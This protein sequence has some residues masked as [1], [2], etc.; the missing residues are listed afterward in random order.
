MKRVL[1]SALLICSAVLSGFVGL[2]LRQSFSYEIFSSPYYKTLKKNLPAASA[3]IGYVAVTLDTRARQNPTFADAK[4]PQL[5]QAI[6]KFLGDSLQMAQI[7][8]P[9]HNE[10]YNEKYFPDLFLGSVLGPQKP[11]Y[12]LADC[13]QE[14][15]DPEYCVRLAGQLGSKAWMQQLKSLMVSQKLNYVIV[16]QLGEGYIYPNG[17]MKKVNA[18][19]ETRKAP[20]AGLDM[21]TGFWLPMSQKLVATNKPIDVLFL[22]GMLI[23]K[24]GKA[25]RYGAEGITAASKASF[26]E[27]TVNIAHE[28][29]EAE[30]N[31]IENDLRRTDLPDQPL[32]WQIAAKNLTRMLTQSNAGL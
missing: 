17:K 11:L 12:V 22:K 7:Q 15:E 5:Q 19:V 9:V 28:F 23:D 13:P 25:V 3:K 32:N 29:S 18:L 10:L 1:L 21:G 26:L 6:N 4:I 27:Q 8:M 31:A 16:Y 14:K 20:P 30:L 2:D 24:E